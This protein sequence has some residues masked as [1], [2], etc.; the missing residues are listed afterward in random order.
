MT[1]AA[2]ST[3][4]TTLDLGLVIAVAR[5]AA[6]LIRAELKPLDSAERCALGDLVNAVRLLTGE[7]VSRPAALALAVDLMRPAALDAAA[8]RLDETKAEGA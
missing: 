6:D 1:T 8:R 2:P 5:E 7:D 4:P 3:P